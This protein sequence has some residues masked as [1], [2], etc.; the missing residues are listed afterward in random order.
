MGIAVDEK[1]QTNFKKINDRICKAE[2]PLQ[3]CTRKMIII[4]TYAPTSVACR[5]DNYSEIRD[6]YYQSL[7]TA[8]N[9]ITNRHINKGLKRKNSAFMQRDS[10]RDPK[11]KKRGKSDNPKLTELSEKQNKMNNEKDKYR[12]Q[13]LQTKSILTLTE[14]KR[15]LKKE[16]EKNIIEKIEQ[17]EN[18]NNDSRRVFLAV[19]QL[20]TTE[21]KKLI[22]KEGNKIVANDEKQVK[23]VTKFCSELLI[24]DTDTSKMDA[25]PT[26][27]KKNLLEMK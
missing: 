5:G 14:I 6:N 12:R 2:I 1:L 18:S 11:K 20:Q 10:R 19:R 8:I 25:K 22:I 24:S 3:N 15:E 21:N 4:C 13:K 26:E 9:N 17:T 27:I 16:E 23:I 7:T